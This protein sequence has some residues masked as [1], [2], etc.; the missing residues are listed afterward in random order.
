LTELL[1]DHTTLH[2]GGAARHFYTAETEADL[3]EL[4][5]DCDSR[6]EPVLVLGGGSNVLVADEGFPGT[7][8]KVATKG[9]QTEDVT[10]CAGAFVNVAA[11][12]TWDDFVQYAL[13][14]AQTQQ[15]FVGIE[16]LS[17]IPGTVGA[18][19]IQNVGA[20]GQEVNQTIAR[21]RTFDRQ[22]GQLK[23]FSAFECYF[24]YRTSIFKR[25]L[26]SLPTGRWV[27]LSVS[28][29]FPLGKLSA[30]VS[31]PELAAKLGIAT[32][33][34]APL[35][36]VR[37]AVLELRRSKG[38]VV[39]PADHDTWSAGSFFTNPL[40]TPEQADMLPSDAPRYESG[41][42]KVK[43]SAAWLIEHAGFGKGYGEPPATLSNKHV[44]ALTNRGEASAADIAALANEIMAGVRDKFGI[45]LAVEPV[46]VGCELLSPKGA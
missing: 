41:G 40:L 4:V 42:G 19:P 21:V 29:R 9:I 44:L 27:I 34:R 22:T 45:T 12:E 35:Q 38:M 11:G 33:K 17:G 46:L 36:A 10:S 2:V 25:S 37:D 20:Y 39:D 14:Q 31:Y 26:A 15:G 43:T 1:S 23:T 8:I 5:K 30:P 18:T 16:A 3:I 7:V 13:D 32:G 6:D 28:F 24:G